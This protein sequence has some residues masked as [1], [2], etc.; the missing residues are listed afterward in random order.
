MIFDLKLCDCSLFTIVCVVV[1]TLPEWL[2]NQRTYEYVMN[3]GM[4]YSFFMNSGKFV[5]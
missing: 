3:S 1:S 2:W 4:W 5:W